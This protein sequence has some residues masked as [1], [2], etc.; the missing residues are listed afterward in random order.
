MGEPGK[1]DADGPSPEAAGAGNG[2][3]AQAERAGD[4]NERL[5]A[6]LLGI[7]EREVGRGEPRRAEEWKTLREMA[8]RHPNGSELV[9][10]FEGVIDRCNHELVSRFGAHG[11]DVTRLRESVVMLI[12]VSLA[13][14][15]GLGGSPAKES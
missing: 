8:E 1:K 3:A 2:Q 10:T 4:A 15:L 13:K 5:N 7:I 11:N 9:T 6:I 14:K 12:R